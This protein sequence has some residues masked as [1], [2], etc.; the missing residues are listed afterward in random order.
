MEI[1]LETEHI[2]IKEIQE[3]IYAVFSPVLTSFAGC[4]SGIIDLGGK[5]IVFDTLASP[6]IAAELLQ[7]AKNLTG[8]T[9]IYAINSHWHWDHVWGNQIFQSNI[10]STNKTRE[11]FTSSND[12]IIQSFTDY[13]PNYLAEAKKTVEMNE[14]GLT[15]L[16]KIELPD[17][18]DF[19]RHV[20]VA[21]KI[22][23]SLDSIKLVPP[24]ITFEAKAI[25]SGQ[26]R[27]A[28]LI[29]FDGLHSESDIIL[30]LHDEK[31]I[32]GG[33][34]IVNGF[35]PMSFAEKP[36]KWKIIFDHISS[37][38]PESIIPGHGDAMNFEELQIIEEYWETCE[39]SAEKAL[40]AGDPKKYV[41]SVNL[42]RKFGAKYIGGNK[43]F[44]DN[45]MRFVT[46]P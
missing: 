17:K 40:E 6:E 39:R 11:L 9:E 46:F 31:I 35:Q 22:N 29:T 1:V 26:E 30:Y 21:E 33:D 28:Q 27:S 12:S 32:W 42:P 23:Q 15:F 37:L 43:T 45:I 5:T 38:K 16:L 34:L 10:I 13:I 36:R 7:H 3:G 4:N 19:F 2:K 8:N 25:I 44:R 14:N 18:E 24:D 41:E 20:K